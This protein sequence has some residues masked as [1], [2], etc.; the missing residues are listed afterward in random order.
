MVCGQFGDS[1]LH[2][3]FGPNQL[4]MV[5]WLVH[6]AHLDIKQPNVVRC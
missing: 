2:L 3:V 6:E 1:G 5:K 4:P